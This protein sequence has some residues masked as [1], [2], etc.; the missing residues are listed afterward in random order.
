MVQLSAT[1]WS[2]FVILWVS[3]VT[4][5]IPCVASRVFIV[6]VRLSPETFGCTLVSDVAFLV[7]SFPQTSQSLWCYKL[8][9]GRIFASKHTSSRSACPRGLTVRRWRSTWWRRCYCTRCPSSSCQWRTVRLWEFCGVPTTS[10]ATLRPWITTAP[11]PATTVSA[12]TPTSS[13][14]PVQHVH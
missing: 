10:Q 13:S 11:P 7:C 3:L 4:A 9:A 8:N 5:I 12:P 14:C 1:R 2:C 6:V